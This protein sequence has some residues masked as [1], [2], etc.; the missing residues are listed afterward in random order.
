MLRLLRSREGEE[1][2]C[3]QKRCGFDSLSSFYLTI[4]PFCGFLLFFTRTLSFFLSFF[5]IH[6][7]PF[8]ATSR[9]TVPG[10]RHT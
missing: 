2:V 6:P 5:L 10:S 3:G 8:S 1:S 4:R 7:T 9:T